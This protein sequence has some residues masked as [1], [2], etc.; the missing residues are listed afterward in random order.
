M[1]PAQCLHVGLIQPRAWPELCAVVL[2]QL[3]LKEAQRDNR[4]QSVDMGGSHGK[5]AFSGEVNTPAGF[6]L[7]SLNQDLRNASKGGMWPSSLGR[8]I[9]AI[10]MWALHCPK[11]SEWMKPT[12]PQRLPLL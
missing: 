10:N 2:S 7:Q 5:N 6:L 3:L 1:A 4:S 8:F 11:L 9:T 12:M